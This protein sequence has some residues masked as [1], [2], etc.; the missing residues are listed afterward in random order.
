MGDDVD[1]LFW[2][3][4]WIGAVPLCERFIRLYL[5]SDFK[6]KSVA[7]MFSLGWGEGGEA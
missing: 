1:T 7:E 2:T 5:L 3:I 6:G 4:K